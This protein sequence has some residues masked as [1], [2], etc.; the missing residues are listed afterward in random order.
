[1][2]CI[3][4]LDV[5][6]FS[7]CSNYIMDMFKIKSFFM[8]FSR[9]KLFRSESRANHSNKYVV[10]LYLRLKNIKKVLCLRT[11]ICFAAYL[12]HV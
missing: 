7:F 10:N 12:T 2:K 1:M 3:Q 4:I 8:A 5:H 11:L 9:L 6:I